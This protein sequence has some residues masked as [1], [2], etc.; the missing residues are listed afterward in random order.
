VGGM[1]SIECVV[2]SCGTGEE[3]VEDRDSLPIG[4]EDGGVA[5]GR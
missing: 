4:G 3:G 1:Q 2:G 5:R